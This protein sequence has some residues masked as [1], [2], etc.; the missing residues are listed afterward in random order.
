MSG[1]MRL[2]AP[3][4]SVALPEVHFGLNHEGFDQTVQAW[5]AYLRRHVL[6]RV[7]DGRQPLIYNHWGFMEHERA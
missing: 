7:G 5:Q 6:Y 4:E 2:L 1:T 3:G